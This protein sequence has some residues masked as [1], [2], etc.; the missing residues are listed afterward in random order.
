[1]Q[2]L[3]IN[4]RTIRAAVAVVADEITKMTAA[5]R[6]LFGPGFP[7]ESRCL[8]V[9]PQQ[10]TELLAWGSEGAADATE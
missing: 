8:L 9:N 2:V 1:M 7:V 6:I 10:M 4:F 3:N 5:K